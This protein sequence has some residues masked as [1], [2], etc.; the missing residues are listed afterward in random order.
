MGAFSTAPIP[1]PQL[2]TSHCATLTAIAKAVVN[3]IVDL[4]IIAEGFGLARRRGRHCGSW[5]VGEETSGSRIV[6]AAAS[7]TSPQSLG[8]ACGATRGVA[9]DASIELRDV[10]NAWG[11]FQ[12]YSVARNN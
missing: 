9:L 8:F 10:I 6:I 3:D 1:I 7:T 11:C 4:E 12:V 2:P 5:G